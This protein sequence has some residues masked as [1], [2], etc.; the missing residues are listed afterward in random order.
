[1]LAAQLGVLPEPAVPLTTI[2]I[3]IPAALVLANLIAAVPGQAAA[4]IRPAAVLRTE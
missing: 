3:V 4:R 2:L 1:L